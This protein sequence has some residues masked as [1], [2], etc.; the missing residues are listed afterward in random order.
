MTL[1]IMFWQNSS[2]A[3]KSLVSK[4]YIL[5]NPIRPTLANVLQI[6]KIRLFVLLLMFYRFEWPSFALYQN[7]LQIRVARHC[8][9]SKCSTDSTALTPIFSPLV[10]CSTDWDAL[11]GCA[12]IARR[13]VKLRYFDHVK[14]AL[15]RESVVDTGEIVTAF[16][17]LMTGTSSWIQGFL[18]YSPTSSTVT[19][20][21]ARIWSAKLRMNYLDAKYLSLCPVQS[22]ENLLSRKILKSRP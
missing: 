14:S 16:S 17:D 6:G 18:T 2:A 13:Q 20:N 19:Q 4:A 7:V 3:R 8:P 11:F 21:P 15:Q 1:F 9:L 10:K 5:K 22:V 12:S